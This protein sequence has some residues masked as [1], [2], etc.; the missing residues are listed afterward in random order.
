MALRIRRISLD[1]TPSTQ[2]SLETLARVLQPAIVAE[3]IDRCAARER[4]A[5]KLP[6]STVLLLCIAMNL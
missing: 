2:L 5:R 1:A 4:R 3:V 6:A